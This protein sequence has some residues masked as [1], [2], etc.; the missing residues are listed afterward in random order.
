M[1]LANVRLIV[2][3]AIADANYQKLLMSNCTEAIKGYEITDDEQQML[4]NL[5]H[6]TY[7]STH[8]GLADILKMVKAAEEY[9]PNQ[10]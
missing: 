1:S 4:E 2:E 3:K 5:A 8:R 9:D 6:G 7:S 10:V